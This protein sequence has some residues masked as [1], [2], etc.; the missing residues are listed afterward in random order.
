M[1][2]MEPIMSYLKRR[3]NE[4]GPAARDLVADECGCSRSIL[5]KIA[6]G[7]RDNCQ[8]NSIQPVLDLLQAV[9][10]GERDLFL[11]KAA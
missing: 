3:L 5:R 11:S 2:G 1:D 10:R 7:D 4:I 8:V 6:Y 9:D